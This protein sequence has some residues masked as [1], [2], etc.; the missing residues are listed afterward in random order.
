MFSLHHVLWKESH[1]RHT[2]D[3]SIKV[4]LDLTYLRTMTSMHYISPF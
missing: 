4:I 3:I 2:N 1:D